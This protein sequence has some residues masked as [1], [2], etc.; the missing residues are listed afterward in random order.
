MISVSAALLFVLLAAAFVSCLR[1]K[2]QRFRRE[3]QKCSGKSNRRSVSERPMS[4]AMELKRV[5]CMSS[6]SASRISPQRTQHQP[7]EV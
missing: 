6:S 1:M 4:N 7:I 5:S 2:R 3:S